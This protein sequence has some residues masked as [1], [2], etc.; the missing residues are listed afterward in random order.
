MPPDIAY[1]FPVAADPCVIALYGVYE[2]Q[3]VAHGIVAL[4]AKPCGYEAALIRLGMDAARQKTADDWAASTEA[5]LADG[6]TTVVDTA[7]Q[8]EGASLL[9]AV[10]AWGQRAEHRCSADYAIRLRVTDC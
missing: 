2:K 9:E 1:K 10:D 5:A 3:A 8:K 4:K 7:V 6:T